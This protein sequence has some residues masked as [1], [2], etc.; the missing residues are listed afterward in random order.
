MPFRCGDMDR[1]LSWN[2]WSAF[3]FT[4]EPFV[5]GDRTGERTDDVMDFRSEPP[6]G[7]SSGLRPDDSFR[8][9]SGDFSASPRRVRQADAGRGGGS[10]PESRRDRRNPGGRS[11]AR[12]VQQGRRVQIRRDLRQRDRFQRYVAHISAAPGQR[13]PECDQPQGCRRQ[14]PD[15]G[16]RQ[17]RPRE[18][19]GLDRIPLDQSRLQQGRD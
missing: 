11:R 9:R 8:M 1:R 3:R 12:D 13:R 17:G 10:H 2:C 6:T 5:R 4:C 16:Y 18:G 19:R 14:V 15:S 7:R